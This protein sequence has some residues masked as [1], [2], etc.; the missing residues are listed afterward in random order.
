MGTLLLSGTLLL[1]LACTG[2][3]SPVKHPSE[4]AVA[5]VL[6]ER[7]QSNKTAIILDAFQILDSDGGSKNFVLQM[8]K[9]GKCYLGEEF[10]GTITASGELKSDKGEILVHLR[11]DELLSDEGKV[12]LLIKEDG[13]IVNGS[14]KDITWGADGRL[15]SDELGLKL[16]P[17]DSKAKRAASLLLYSFFGSTETE[18]QK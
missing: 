7:K 1:L 6:Q 14:G 10:L 9:E 5:A 4:D 11:G 12:I 2:Q 8:D 15:K 13:T 17:A 18:V 3:S 16:V